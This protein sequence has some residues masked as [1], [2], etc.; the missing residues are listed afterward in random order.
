MGCFPQPELRPVRPFLP[1]SP[2]STCCPGLDQTQMGADWM[3]EPGCKNHAG[4]RHPPWV[5][6]PVPLGRVRKSFVLQE[7]ELL[8]NYFLW[9]VGELAGPSG[10][11]WV[12]TGRHW[13]SNQPCAGD[14][15]N[16]TAEELATSQAHG[17][18]APTFMWVCLT[19]PAWKGHQTRL[20]RYVDGWQLL[21]VHVS[22]T[23]KACCLSFQEPAELHFPRGTRH[24][25]HAV[26]ATPA[27]GGV[28]PVLPLAKRVF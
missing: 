3:A 17:K 5:M 28:V 8:C 11:G 4:K 12:I 2:A 15:A 18:V 6:L 27:A 10:H 19:G 1:S 22:S 21:W 25:C 14:L 23:L 24:F 7:G 16:I 20:R 9:A 13:R 26:C